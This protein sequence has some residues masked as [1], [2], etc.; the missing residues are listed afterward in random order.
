MLSAATFED[1]D[2]EFSSFL[3]SCCSGWSAVGSGVGSAAS[4]KACCWGSE[5]SLMM[6]SR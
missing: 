2:E 3:S 5:A 6:S 4:S 1:E